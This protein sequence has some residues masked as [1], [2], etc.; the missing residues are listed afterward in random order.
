MGKLIV[1]EILL[2]KLFIIEIWRQKSKNTAIVVE[3]NC[4]KHVLKTAGIIPTPLEFS[5]PM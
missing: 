4:Q 2:E 1:T 3:K 5:S